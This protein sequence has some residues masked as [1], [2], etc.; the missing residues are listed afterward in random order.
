MPHYRTRN[1]SKKARFG[2]IERCSF[3]AMTHFLIGNPLTFGLD[4]LLKSNIIF[5]RDAI[6]ILFRFFFS[7]L[8]L[9]VS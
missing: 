3:V 6:K 9:L 5:A 4:L 7:V 8:L 2:D 1:M